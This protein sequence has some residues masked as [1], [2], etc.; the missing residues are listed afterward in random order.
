MTYYKATKPDGTS[1]YDG[2]TKWEVGK[3]TSLPEGDR[4]HTLCSAGLLH[5]STEPGESLTGG[6]WP[7]RLFVVELVGELI[8]DD[9]HP[10]KVG[11]HEWLVT[12][13][14][15][16]WKA[17]GPNGKRVAELIERCKTLTRDELRR[18]A[19][20]WSAASNAAWSAAWYAASSAAWNAASSAASN[21][22]WSAALNAAW[23]AAWNAASSA[24]RDAALA[25]LTWDLATEDGPY[26]VEMRDLLYAPWKEVMGE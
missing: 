18:L 2:T 20:A 5:A 1:F 15:E 13:E 21:A 10:Y 4:K 19:R 11:A 22:A 23:N 26:T 14:I 17:L 25:L 12:E 24:S 9:D 6:W 8:T 7:C 16:A 3:V